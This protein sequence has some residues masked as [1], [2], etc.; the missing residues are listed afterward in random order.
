MA[1][2]DFIPVCEPFLGEKELQNVIEA[3]KSGWISSKG[4]FVNEFEEKFSAYCNANYGI[5]T[6]NG[7]T[8]LHLAM[9]ATG[10]GKGDEVII[11]DFTMISS[12]NAAVY[13]GAKPVFVDADPITW[14]INPS[15]IEEK[16]TKNTK[17]IMPVHLYGH[18]CD[19]DPILKIAKE[20]SLFVIEDAA[21]AHGAEYKGKKVGCLGDVGCFSFYANKLVTTGEGGMVLTNDEK[22]AEKAN[23]YK[24]LCFD[25]ERRYVHNDIGF[26]F[27]ATNIQAA[28]GIAQLERIETTIQIKRKNAQLYNSLLKNIDGI[29]TPPEANWAKNVYWMYT[30]LVED[31]FGLSRDDLKKELRKKGIDT[32]F[33]FSPMHRQPCFEKLGFGDNDKF[34]TVSNELS[35]KG[36]YLPSGST[37]KE[38]QINYI[39]NAL[40]EIKGN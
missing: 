32:R 4:K 23:Y 30:I 1:E 26:N 34:F 28:I 11:P 17:A 29:T 8:A 25:K 6:S 22:I 7:T 3:V 12:A 31:N 36:I 33:S 39:V 40:K 27:R 35:R 38:E 21:E 13:V 2:N 9:L 10:I 24:D 37:L 14:N 5:F 20:H 18:P 19:M 16:I 15:K